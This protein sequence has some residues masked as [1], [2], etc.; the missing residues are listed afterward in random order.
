MENKV[1]DKSA[2]DGIKR[3]DGHLKVTGTIKYA[4]EY[5]FPGLVYG[6]LVHSTIAKGTITAIDDKSAKNAP[7]V[8]AIISHL[9]APNIPGYEGGGHES[10][11]KTFN[12]NRIYFNGQPIVLVVADT[13][14]RAKY[15]ASLVK[16]QYNK[17]QHQT[18]LDAGLQN[19][20]KPWGDGSD[21]LRGQADAYLTAPVKIE[22]EYRTPI[23]VH[24]AMEP[25]AATVVWNGNDKVTVYSK[26]QYIKGLQ[27]N[28]MSLFKLPEEN[29]TVY[30]KVLG[31]AFGSGSGF[32]PHEKAALIGGRMIGKPLKV[33]IDREQMFT[34][35]GYRSPAIQKIG[36]GATADGKLVGIT[37]LATGETSTYQ[38]FAEG[39][40]DTTKFLYNCPNIN[41]Q[42]RLARL[43][44]STPTYTRGPGE[45][46]GVFALESAMDELAYALKMDPLELRKRNYADTDQE[47][48]LPWSS[49]YLNECYEQGA[50]KFGWEKRNPIPGAVIKDGWLVG[51]GVGSGA[52]GA[53]R[54][55]CTVHAKMND[56]GAV[57]L[58]TATSDMGPGTATVMTKIAADVL[59]IPSEKIKFELGS[60]L[61][62]NAPG[63]Y[64]SMTTSS[65]G[66]AVFD[67]CSALK[68]QLQ[69]L[70]GESESGKLDYASVLKT[71]NL[72]YY[73]VTVESSRP[74]NAR[75]YSAHAY[76]TH[77]VEVNVHPQTGIVKVTRVVSAVDAGKILNPITARSQIYGGV[78]WGIS[79]SLME[80]GVID[81]RYGKY[82]NSN[83]GEY[84][85]AS[86][87]DVPQVDVIFIDKPDPVTNPMGSKG[88]GEVTLVGF[89][90]AV[91]NAIF[92][93]TG[94][95][96][97]E[98]P[99]TPDKLVG[100]S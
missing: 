46:T 81:H 42:Y 66:S 56:D 8:V 68:K 62:P 2:A 82:V 45:T 92:N 65:V 97:R 52:Y 48:N 39:I 4:A 33:V 29:V 96:I 73:E 24:N 26:S 11:I 31:G 87:M 16:V 30:S 88:L 90:A 55:N 51:Y 38:Q 59:E 37:H 71:H 53:G 3:V 10:G 67:S 57:L 47:E 20:Y 13:L 74:A 23:H 60:S 63:E 95:R 89:A 80:G 28:I 61:L 54:A 12:D 77:F 94:K 44:L 14:E 79:M 25:F 70:A 72:P 21:Y 49:K 41:T 6:V 75:N 69:V 5:N 27:H 32:W 83:L 35:V 15:A 86:N 34:M 17:E 50:A 85:F 93:A 58:Q 91:T 19:I 100:L 64:G 78:V 9:N 7:G 22:A 98:L 18:S 99:V 1:K 76:C 84:H 36:M 40:T 43:D